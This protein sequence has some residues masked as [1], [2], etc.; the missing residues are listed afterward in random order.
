MVG[1]IHVPHW[2]QVFIGGHAL[3]LVG[4]IGKPLGMLVL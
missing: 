3:R 1:G 4:G 2:N